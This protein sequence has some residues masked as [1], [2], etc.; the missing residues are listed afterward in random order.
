MEHDPK[1]NGVVKLL[2]KLKDSNGSYPPDLLTSRR[3]N[4]IRQMEITGITTPR[5]QSQTAPGK[6]IRTKNPDNHDEDKDKVKDG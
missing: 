3:R 2:T 1:V 4:F 5:P 6:T